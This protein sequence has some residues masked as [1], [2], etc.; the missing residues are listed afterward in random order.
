MPNYLATEENGWKKNF[1]GFIRPWTV[2][3]DPKGDP[4]QFVSARFYEGLR[5]GEHIPWGLWLRPLFSWA[6]FVALIFTA[7]LCLAVIVRRQWVDNE[8]L[9][10]PLV[11]LPLEMVR[12]ESSD[13]TSFLRNRM[14]WIGFLLPTLLFGFN[15]L[16]QWYPSIP[17]VA[18]DIDL[19]SFLHDR[20]WNG[21]TFFHIYLSLAAVG[22]FFLLPT[23]VIFCFWFF[24]LFT[25][26]EEV[27]A[28]ALG[29]EPIVM[30]LSGCKEFIGYQIIGCYVVLVGTMIYSAR[31][32]LT[33]V[34]QCAKTFGR[35]MSEEDAGE[36]LSY[37]T[38]FWGLMAC[39]LLS[40]GWMSL[41]GM[42]YWL[43]LCELCVLIFVVAFGDGEV[44]V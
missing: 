43:A 1:Y 33:R 10:F 26:V 11:Q 15:G 39:V 40:A 37:R 32:H 29:Y 23:D 3:F 34:W 4:G 5:F 27:G 2:P 18:T 21:V 25:K 19:N 28:S 35:R 44:Y 24:F 8:K 16:H 42:A 20:P 7:Y 12:G 22:F 38:A 30:P 41:L 13:G 17:D 31:P 14:T 9:A 6:V 36:L